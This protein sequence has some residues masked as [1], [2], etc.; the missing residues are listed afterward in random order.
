MVGGT[1][2]VGRH[3]VAR[4]AARGHEVR[5][6]SRHAREHP[7]DLTTGAGLAA[8]LDGVDV[9][10]DASNTATSLRHV[11]AAVVDGTRRLLAAE[12]DAEVR[13]HVLVSVVG[14]HDVPM[15]YYA[16]KVA[17]EREVADG[18]VPW[19]VVAATQFHELVAATLGAA[20]R[21][22]V[23]PLLRAPVQ[24][25]AAAEV[26]A[27]VADAAERDPLGR[28]TTVAGPEAVDLRDLARAWRDVT[29]SRAAPVRVPLPGALGRALRAGGRPAPPPPAR[30]TPASRDRL[31]AQHAERAAAR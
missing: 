17:Q 15:A 28:I 14:C 9:V 30:G 13:H 19:T 26:G 3:V 21:R 5:A 18:G 24:P 31:A 29:G 23:V 27:A 8:A 25:V 12:R 4:L 7:V 22:G 20:A 1:G 16:A 6:L 11:R 10:V 2:T